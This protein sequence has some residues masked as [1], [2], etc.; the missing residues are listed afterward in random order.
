M[1]DPK[2]GTHIHRRVAMAQA[3]SP[4]AVFLAAAAQAERCAAGDHDVRVVPRTRVVY[5]PFGRRR[6]T[7]DRYCGACQTDLPAE[8]E[9]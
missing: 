5:A 8:G 3:A 9:G 6:Q 7:G 2:P 1:G 4:A